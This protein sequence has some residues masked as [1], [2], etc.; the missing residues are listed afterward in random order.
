MSTSASSSPAS[1][2]AQ[3][4]EP[5]RWSHLPIGINFAAAAYAFNEGNIFLD[6][7]L[8]VDD[9]HAEIHTLAL[10]YVRTFGLF[11]NSARSDRGHHPGW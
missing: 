7:A 6:S 8:L 4:L 3:E 11:G 5:R 1:L 9:A 2:G 10:G